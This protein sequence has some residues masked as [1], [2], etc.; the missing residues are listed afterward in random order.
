[1]GG[2]RV[3]DSDVRV[4]GVGRPALDAAAHLPN[5]TTVPRWGDPPRCHVSLLELTPQPNANGYPINW[6]SNQAIRCSRTSH[7]L[8]ADF[9]FW[10]LVRPAAAAPPV[11][12]ALG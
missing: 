5:E 1:M 2:D 7:Y 12:G 3:L 9:D 8:I 11:T 10:P 6:L 4:S